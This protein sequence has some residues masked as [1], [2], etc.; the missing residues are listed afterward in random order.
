LIL[1]K[2]KY[3]FNPVTLTFEEIK[4]SKR[5]RT[6][7]FISHTFISLIVIFISGLLFN[8]VLDSP[9]SIKLKNQIV[10]LHQEMKKLAVK[11]NEFSSYLRKDLF[12]K[13]NTYRMILQMD[14]LPGS[15]LIAGR[16]GSAAAGELARKGDLEYQVN[17]IIKSLN[18]QVQI[19]S[20]SIK[21]LDDKVQEYSAVQTHMPAILPVA[22]KDLIMI[23]TDFGVRSD[24]FSF[25]SRNHN[26]LD[27]IAPAGKNVFATGDGIVTFV[28]HSRTGY[29]NEIVIDHGFGFASRYAHLSLILVKN[30]E[31]VKRGQIVGKVGETG[32]TTGPHLHYEVLYGHKPVNPSY[33]FDTDLT[34]E[35]FDQII[36][37]AALR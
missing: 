28:Q 23:S 26:G 31:E 35:E 25:L 19:Q 11:G 6:L 17:D 10:R 29:G 20:A 27:F 7:I 30:N 5:D 37:I 21:A 1:R 24:P 9:E 36:N 34:I 3:H 12:K 14:T 32:R 13:D 15:I 33:Y 16:G 22:Q 18:Y 8:W 4:L 2:K